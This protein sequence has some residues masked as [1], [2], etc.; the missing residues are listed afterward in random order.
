[1]PIHRAVSRPQI[2]SITSISF[3]LGD[4]TGVVLNRLLSLSQYPVRFF[5]YLFRVLFNMTDAEAVIAVN[6]VEA[7]DLPSDGRGDVVDTGVTP[8][9]PTPI[10]EPPR[11]CTSSISSRKH[12]RVY[13]DRDFLLYL[14]ETVYCKK[15]P[16]HLFKDPDL[17]F[18]RRD[19]P[20]R[21][22]MTRAV[23][24]TDHIKGP[25]SPRKR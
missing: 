8:K 14:K 18:I 4:L 21:G 20:T 3:R 1:M 7:C 24:I 10:P 16:E 9:P 17:T 22:G 13:V 6:V 25:V 5:R 15:F 2:G 19:T 11:S 12:H 23:S